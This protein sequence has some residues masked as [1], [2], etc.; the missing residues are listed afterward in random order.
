MTERPVQPPESR[1]GR[2]RL[3]ARARRRVAFALGVLVVVGTVIIAAVAYQR[4]EGADVQGSIAGYQVLD[5]ET[6]SVTISVTR[7]DPAKPVSCI[8]RVRSRDGSETGRREILVPPSEGTT[9]QVKT[10][11][12]AYR[13]PYVGDIYGCGADVPSY[14]VSP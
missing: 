7:K 6:V 8:V 2:Q 3:S 1:Y 10:T 14:L 4:F 5:N 13:P 12:K 9:V 11:V